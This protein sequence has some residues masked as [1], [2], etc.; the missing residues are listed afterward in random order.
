MLNA[1][2]INILEVLLDVHYI[3][4]NTK[5]RKKIDIEIISIFDKL[6]SS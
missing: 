5:I 3:K 2:L 1:H 4:F 6:K